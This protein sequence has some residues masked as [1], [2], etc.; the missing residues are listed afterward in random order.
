MKKLKVLVS[1][2]LSF[3]LLLP[4]TAP[5]ALAASKH[6]F[7]FEFKHQVTS[8]T[9]SRGASNIKIY[10]HADTG[11]SGGTFNIELYRKQKKAKPNILALKSSLKTVQLQTVME[12]KLKGNF[13]LL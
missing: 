10:T 6:D 5:A 2:A 1:S 3:T 9:Y 12:I 4:V 7:W 11:G 8:K 13:I